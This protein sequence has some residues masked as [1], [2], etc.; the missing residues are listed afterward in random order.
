MGHVVINGKTVEGD[1]TGF[2]FQITVKRA[3]QN[4]DGTWVTP[5]E[6]GLQEAARMQ[7]TAVY[8]L[9]RQGMVAQ[10]VAMCPIFELLTREKVYGG[11]GGQ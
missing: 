9:R 2:L 5:E 3:W 8:I 6:G 10:W 1:H 4:L 11:W 7:L